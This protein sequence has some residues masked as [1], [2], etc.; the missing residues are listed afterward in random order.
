MFESRQN[1]EFFCN[2]SEALDFCFSNQSQWSVKPILAEWPLD[3]LEP[4]NKNESVARDERKRMVLGFTGFAR[5]LPKNHDFRQF[6]VN[7]LT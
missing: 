3:E 2:P 1:I 7:A 6:E 4:R 5:L